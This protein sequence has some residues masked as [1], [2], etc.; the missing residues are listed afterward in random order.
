MYI[1]DFAVSATISA[2]TL[3]GTINYPNTA[4]TPL[5]G[6]SIQLKNTNGTVI[7]TTTTNASGQ[8]SFSSIPNGNYTM[9]AT[10][11]KPWGGS[12]AADVLLYKKHIADIEPLSGIFLASGDVNA[13][14]EVTALDVLL[15]RKRIA[16]LIY[17]FPAGD[18]L[19]NN[20]PVIINGGNIIQD[21][22]GLTYGDANGSYIP[23]GSK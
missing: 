15:I 16:N 18:W 4:Q 21:F 22:Y 23:A 13:S 20:T 11:A 14:G 9:V 19:F 6:I 1:D 17:S 3:S 5:Q 10:T 7:S 8:Y 12:T 2:Y